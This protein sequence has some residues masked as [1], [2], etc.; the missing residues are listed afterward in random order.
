MAWNRRGFDALEKDATKVLAKILPDLTPSD[1]ILLHEAT[2][3]AAEVLGGVLE[4]VSRLSQP[5]V[6]AKKSG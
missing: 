5:G 6:M 2:P 4:K 3:I 1:I